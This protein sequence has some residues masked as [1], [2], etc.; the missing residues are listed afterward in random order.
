M[1][2]PAPRPAFALLA[3]GLLLP[4]AAGACAVFAFAPFGYWP[5]ALASLA[6]LFHVWS[7]SGTPLQAALSGIAFGLGLNLAGVSW[8][9]VSLHEYGHMPA[10]L[11]AVATF[12]FCAF[13]G[14]FPG[15]AGWAAHRFGG[16]GPWRALLA[17]PAWFALFE[18]VRGWIFTGFPWLVMG[19]SQV[20]ASPLAGFAPVLGVYGVSFVL[21]LAAAAAAALV[22]SAPWSRQRGLLLACL[23]ALF[24]LGGL[25][26]LA[27]WTVPAGEPVAVS[28]LQGNVSQHL[29]FSGRCAR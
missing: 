9:F 12:L 7:G 16:A 17:F 5:V 8:V 28:L 13:V 19:Y 2:A 21:A 6:V 15:F 18:W 3:R 27:E 29:K 4:L 10:V 22:T 25:A 24:A 23:A 20:P 14:L 11:A 26:R 1:S